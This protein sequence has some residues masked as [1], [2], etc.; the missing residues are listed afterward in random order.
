M[1]RL[2]FKYCR[3]IASVIVYM[4]SMKAAIHV[5]ILLL[6]ASCNAVSFSVMPRMKLLP[7]QCSLH[8]AH[9]MM[10]RRDSNAPRFWSL[11]TYVQCR[12]R[13]RLL[14]RTKSIR[15]RRVGI[16]DSRASLW[17]IAMKSLMAK[18]D[19]WPLSCPQA[20]RVLGLRAGNA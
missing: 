11:Q 4:V 13:C 16:L 15:T 7:V 14:T 17:M 1:I 8:H 10:P 20:I 3:W 12:L 6:T 9:V 19:N 18:H 2:K 5:I